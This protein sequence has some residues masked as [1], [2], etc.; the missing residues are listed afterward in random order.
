M[1]LCPTMAKLLRSFPDAD[2]GNDPIVKLP[3]TSYEAA[4]S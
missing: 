3:G 2:V 1:E 4:D